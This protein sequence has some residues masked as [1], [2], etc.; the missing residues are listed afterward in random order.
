MARFLIAPKDIRELYR[1]LQNIAYPKA[2]KLY[3]KYHY[4]AVG[5]ILLSSFCF[6]NSLLR[7]GESIGLAFIEKYQ[8]RKHG[9]VVRRC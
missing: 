2:S 9:A 5:L 4:H 7:I 1:Q 8:Q 6:I 3:V